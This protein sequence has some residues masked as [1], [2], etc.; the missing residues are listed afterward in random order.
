MSEGETRKPDI[1]DTVPKTDEAGKTVFEPITTQSISNLEKLR[2]RKAV[3]K[4]TEA[5]NPPPSS[6]ID[7]KA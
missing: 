6:Y 4:Y 7:K 2:Q 1:L 3:Q 5:G